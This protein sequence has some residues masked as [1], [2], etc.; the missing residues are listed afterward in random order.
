MECYEGTT[1]IKTYKGMLA[2]GEQDRIRLKT[3]K[4]DIGYR[5]VKFELIPQK[6]GASGVYYEAVTKIWKLKQSSIDAVIDFTDGDLLAAGM[7]GADTATHAFYGPMI[8][9]FDQDIFNQ[10][11]YITNSDIQADASLNYYLELEQVMLNDNES[12][13]ATLQSLRQI[14]ER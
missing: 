5:I 13:M 12:T 6:P 4:G 8:T 2:T 9:V 11:I 1:M 14:A 10:D 7:F 3:N